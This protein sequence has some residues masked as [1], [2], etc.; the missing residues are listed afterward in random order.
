MATRK[1]KV[2]ENKPESLVS[3][4]QARRDFLKEGSAFR[5]GDTAGYNTFARHKLE[6]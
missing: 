1:T 6:L 5:C 4:A 2:A 3:E